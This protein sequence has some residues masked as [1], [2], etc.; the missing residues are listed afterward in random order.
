[1]IDSTDKMWE[2]HQKIWLTQ[3]SVIIQIKH[4]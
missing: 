1:M 4:K 3:K 2:Q